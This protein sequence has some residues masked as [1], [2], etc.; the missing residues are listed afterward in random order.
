MKFKPETWFRDYFNKKFIPERKK[1][2]LEKWDKKTEEEKKKT[3]YC[4]S[5]FSDMFMFILE[6]GKCPVCGGE[7][8]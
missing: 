2:I 6:G 4:I 3:Y 8:K 1:I 7:N 5:C